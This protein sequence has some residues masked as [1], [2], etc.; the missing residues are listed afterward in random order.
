METTLKERYRLYREHKF[1]RA[2]LSNLE[3]Q[4]AC[5]DFTDSK[6]VLEIQ[7]KLEEI[8]SILKNHAEHENKIIHPLLRAK[9]SKVIDSIEADHEDY[10]AVFENLTS[11]IRDILRTTNKSELIHK[12]YAFY[13]AYRQFLAMDLRHINEEELVI[14]P[15]LQKYYS[16]KE[17]KQNI[18]FPIYAQMSLEDMIEMMSTLFPYMNVDDK[19]HFLSDIQ[20]AEPEKFMKVWQ[21][22]AQKLKLE[23]ITNLYK[24]LG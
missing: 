16:D 12:G 21:S 6:Q 14:M 13:I 4:I 15:E 3:N 20:E 24:K 11:R 8:F 2:I 7:V 19:K 18:D 10:I 22:I 23:E 5:A 1:L 17:L 9:N